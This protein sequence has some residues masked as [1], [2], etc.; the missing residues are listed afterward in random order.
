MKV[1][2]HECCRMDSHF[3]FKQ[4]REN[5]RLRLFC[6]CWAGLPNNTSTR[7]SRVGLLL[8]LA[9]LVQ[10]T[11]YYGQEMNNNKKKKPKLTVDV[12]PRNLPSL[13]PAS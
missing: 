13:E 3:K 8:L 9:L 2:N 4:S 7:R 11:A 5:P 12:T 1:Y 10:S 6:S